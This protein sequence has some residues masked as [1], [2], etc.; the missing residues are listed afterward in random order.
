MGFDWRWIVSGLIVFAVFKLSEP[1]KRVIRI[2]DCKIRQLGRPVI[3]GLCVRSS[4]QR[5]A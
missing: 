5:F 2:G 3:H 4:R 1:L